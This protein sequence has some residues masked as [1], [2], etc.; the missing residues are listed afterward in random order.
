MDLY[1]AKDLTFQYFPARF[2]VVSDS[3]NTEYSVLK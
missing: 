3:S 1:I 2:D